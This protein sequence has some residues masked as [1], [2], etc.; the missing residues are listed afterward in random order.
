[1]AAGEAE[2]A[3]GEIDVKA[4]DLL[5]D[6]W[7]KFFKEAGHRRLGRILVSVAKANEESRAKGQTKR[8]KKAS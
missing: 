3:L 6:W 5:A 8:K 1:M 2:Q 7:N 4:V